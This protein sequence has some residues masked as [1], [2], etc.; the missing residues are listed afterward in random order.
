MILAELKD[1]RFQ[2]YHLFFTNEITPAFIE[3]LATNDP[4]DRIKSLQEVYLDYF[5]IG[6]NVYT[7]NIPSTVSLLKPKEQWLEPQ[8]Q[9]MDRMYQGLLSVIMS[10]RVI[11]QVRYLT[12]SDACFTLAHRLSRKLEIE[13]TEKRS[14]YRIDDRAILIIME[15]KEDVVTPLLIPWTYQAMIHEFIGLANNKVDLVNK[16]KIALGVIE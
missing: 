8:N 1:P 12:N 6:R 16:Q 4:N 3:T 15:R 5:A 13:A 10:L 7:L 14:D 11:P 9:L 2:D